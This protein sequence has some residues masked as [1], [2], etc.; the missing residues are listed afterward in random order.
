MSDTDYQKALEAAKKEIAELLPQHTAIEK[1][2]AKLRQIIAT[3]SSLAEEP[4][5]DDE[6]VFVP[7][8][9]G[10]AFAESR[11]AA[12][13]MFG[14]NMPLSNAVREVLKASGKPM[15]PVQVRDGLIRM[16]IDL[17][18]KYTSP[19]AVI[20]KALKRLDGKNEVKRDSEEE[21]TATTY[22]W[23]AQQGPS[24][25]SAGFSG[26]SSKDRN[27]LR[28]HAEKLENE[29]SKKK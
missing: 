1:R 13:A 14:K 6:Q 4:D 16:G 12:E 29:S 9:I 20:H 5:S 3:L 15:T 21:T 19:L 22:Q 2:I 7:G 8:G 10:R 24:A 18:K 11:I 28:E 25:R 27:Y 17:E 26:V 23:R